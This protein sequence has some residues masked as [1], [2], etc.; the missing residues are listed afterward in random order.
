MFLRVFALVAV[1]SAIV[2]GTMDHPASEENVDKKEGM[3]GY[4]VRQR[5]YHFLIYIGV[6]T[7]PDRC[8]CPSSA[9]LEA[10]RTVYVESHQETVVANIHDKSGNGIGFRMIGKSKV[11]ILC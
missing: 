4:L 7:S 2:V 9:W 3:L 10:V 8:H 6:Q 5:M 11:R 1:I